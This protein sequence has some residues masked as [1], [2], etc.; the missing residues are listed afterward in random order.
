MHIWTFGRSNSK[1]KSDQKD[2]PIVLKRKERIN[3]ECR[4]NKLIYQN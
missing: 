4:E 1:K 2:M 3:S